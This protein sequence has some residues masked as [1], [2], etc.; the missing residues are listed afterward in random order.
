MNLSTE[1]RQ[2]SALS[3][4]FLFHRLVGQ[5]TKYTDSPEERCDR[6]FCEDALIDTEANEFCANGKIRCREQANRNAAE[7]HQNY[8]ATLAIGY[9]QTRRG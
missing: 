6:T 8:R 9:H 2:A 1:N 3:R 4:K 7:D 5:P